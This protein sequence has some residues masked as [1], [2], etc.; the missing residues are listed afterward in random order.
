MKIHPFIGSMERVIA[1]VIIVPSLGCGEAKNTGSLD[2]IGT[3]LLSVL[4]PI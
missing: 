4:D 3:F 1:E 2:M